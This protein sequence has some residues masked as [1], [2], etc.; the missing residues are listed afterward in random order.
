MD[1]DATVDPHSGYRSKEVDQI[2]HA[3]QE[4]FSP[5]ILLPDLSAPD[6]VGY[7]MEVIIMLINHYQ[8]LSG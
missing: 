1:R 5:Y 2:R 8:H 3:A 4:D 6:K 7:H